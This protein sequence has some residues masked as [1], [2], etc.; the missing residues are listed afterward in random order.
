MH[1]DL[2]DDEP[3]L[4]AAPV[5]DEQ[6]KPGLLSR[7]PSLIKRP[8]PMPEPELVMAEA[9]Y[10]FDSMP[11]DDRIKAKINDVIKLYHRLSPE[12]GE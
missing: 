2:I 6:P 7:V 1:A 9:D 11:G 8:E 4:E 10:D 5:Q 12:F 3:I